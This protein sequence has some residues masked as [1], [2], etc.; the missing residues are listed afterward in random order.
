M[1]HSTIHYPASCQGTLNTE[2]CKCPTERT[3]F[4]SHLQSMANL[5]FCRHALAHK[6]LSQPVRAPY[7]RFNF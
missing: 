1:Y 2:Y 3:Y 5:R 4:L 7:K 6:F